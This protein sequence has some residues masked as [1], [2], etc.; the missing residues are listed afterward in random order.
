MDEVQGALKG[1][2]AD[3]LVEVFETG[4]AKVVTSEGVIVAAS[5]S[6]SSLVDG[7]MNIHVPDDVWVHIPKSLMSSLGEG[8]VVFVAVPTKPDPSLGGPPVVVE[9]A[10]QASGYEPVRVQNMSQPIILKLASN[11]FANNLNWIA[12]GQIMTQK[13]KCSYWDEDMNL[14]SSHGMWRVGPDQLRQL[15]HSV[16]PDFQG[17]WCASTH[18]TFFG[19]FVTV[20]AEELVCVSN[21]LSSWLYGQVWSEAL[22]DYK[23]KVAAWW[24]RPPA[25]VLWSFSL[26]LLSLF[27]VTRCLDIRHARAW[28]DDRFL[29]A[30]DI[31]VHHRPFGPCLTCCPA[32]VDTMWFKEAVQRFCSTCTLCRLIACSGRHSGSAGRLIDLYVVV[33]CVHARLATK[34]GL[35]ESALKQHVWG[36]RG[37]VKGICH[38][39]QLLQEVVE[40]AQS[41]VNRSFTLCF[42][43][44][45]FASRFWML[46]RAKHAVL[47]LCRFDTAKTRCKRAAEFINYC[48]GS[49]AIVALYFSSYGVMLSADN[50]YPEACQ[51]VLSP[52]RLVVI[53]LASTML[54]NIPV[55]LISFYSQ[56]KF[57]NVNEWDAR[58]RQQ[59]R[60]SWRLQD[61]FF[62]V[63]S[64]A[65]GC[66][67][68]FIITSFLANLSVA[69]DRKWNAIA[70]VV[71]AWVLLL[72]PLIGS[73]SLSMKANA[74]LHC[75]PQL[76]KQGWIFDVLGIKVK[77]PNEE[78]E[79]V[80][81]HLSLDARK[82]VKELTCRGISIKHLLEFYKKLGQEV[83]LNFDPEKST[84]D[85]V[86]RQ[87][88][89][90]LTVTQSEAAPEL[91]T[92][93]IDEL[94]DAG[95]CLTGWLTQSE[96]APQLDTAF[97]DALAD[98]GVCLT[99]WLAE[100]PVKAPDPGRSSGLRAS[101]NAATPGGVHG[102]GVA[103]ATLVSEGEPKLPHALVTH[104]WGNRF[105]HLVATILADALGSDDF[106]E[107]S[108]RLAPHRIDGLLSEVHERGQMHVTYWVCTFSVN[109]HASMCGLCPGPSLGIRVKTCN[110]PLKKNWA[111]DAC[112]MNSFDDMMKYLSEMVPDLRQIVASDSDFHEEHGLMVTAA[113]ANLTNELLSILFS[114]T[115][116]DCWCLF[117]RPR[118]D[119]EGAL[120]DNQ[121]CLERSSGEFTVGFTEPVPCDEATAQSHIGEADGKT[122][123]LQS[124][125][126]CGLGSSGAITAGF[127]E[128]VSDP[129]SIFADPRSDAAALHQNQRN[130][131]SMAQLGV[132]K[133]GASAVGLAEPAFRELTDLSTEAPSS[134]STGLE[135][136]G[137]LTS[138]FSQP[139]DDPSSV[140]AHPRDGVNAQRH[141]RHR[142]QV[143]LTELASDPEGSTRRHNQSDIPESMPTSFDPEDSA[144]RRNQSN[145]IPRTWPRSLDPEDKGRNQSEQMCL[146]A[147]VKYGLDG[148]TQRRN[149]SEQ[150]CLP[151][152]VKYGLENSRGDDWRIGPRPSS[153]DEA[154]AKLHKRRHQRRTSDPQA[155]PQ[156][157]TLNGR[158]GGAA[159]TAG[160]RD[161][162]GAQ[163]NHKSKE[164]IDYTT[165]NQRGELAFIS[166]V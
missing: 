128:P 151:A 41:D 79:D 115:V 68:L 160:P 123:I 145:I 45:G 28:S 6:N 60:R 47:E 129:S 80:L 153:L 116:F 76:L 50:V 110:S 113:Q 61:S 90:P 62:W 142:K 112:E 17:L 21:G 143:G 108:R 43:G 91:D 150:M 19:A 81:S 165:V 164:A 49:L 52:W 92:A 70:F 133:S 131:H 126:H 83:M 134:Q 122:M 8:A 57:F 105:N 66:F 88:I 26:F 40:N 102:K 3:M 22:T 77:P 98:A 146:P 138:A 33:G 118:R 104:H 1:S 93:F 14:W 27:L 162:S 23:R 58:D 86:V 127:T 31:D 24:K 121:Y 140:F 2:K 137:A 29:I 55:R 36:F 114:E 59:Q 13:T 99:G 100:A 25:I 5:L 135:G 65:H 73:I 161:K 117:P 37:S 152:A 148:S 154:D 147:A 18:L 155:T 103:Y 132:D 136:S 89:I 120:C 144:H 39:S 20:Y 156:L 109:H 11:K 69:E 16:S 9:V 56:R 158:F 72:K 64:I 95:V 124:T 101:A 75:R 63:C 30:M 149:P 96:A 87:A 106:V 125:T 46:F 71:I 48:L 53:G 12:K 67:C 42:H 51:Q 97:I 10:S 107:L 35:T 159:S 4:T 111:G 74:M 141:S 34:H 38:Q 15:G 44:M 85:D 166:L 32:C 119:E 54:A 7:W 84:T 139:V 130:I 78:P 163:R 82:K 94:A 157:G